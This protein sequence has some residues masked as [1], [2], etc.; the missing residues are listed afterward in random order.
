MDVQKMFDIFT[1]YGFE[2]DDVLTDERKLEALNETYW[3]ASG[4]E[5]W[6]FLEATATYTFAGGSATPITPATDIDIVEAIYRTSDGKRIEPWRRDDFFQTYASNLTQNGSPSLYY[7][8]G[9]ALN[10]YPLPTSSDVV[11]VKYHKIP[12]ALLQTTLEASVL[13]PPK[14]HRSV[15]VMGALSRLA[16]A[17]DDVDMSNAYERLYEKALAF[18]VADQLDQQSDRPDFIHVNDP[19]NWDYS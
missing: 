13:F 6:P 15:L 5:D 4:R 11:V 3:D 10:F 9:G 19:D 14:F 7:F 16:L 17:Q 8:E 18:M 1:A 2:S 12:P